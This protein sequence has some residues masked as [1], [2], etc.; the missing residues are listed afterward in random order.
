[1]TL[2]G[3][4]LIRGTPKIFRYLR[5]EKATRGNFNFKV[6][7]GRGGVK[8]LA[9]TMVIVNVVSKHVYIILI[10]KKV[11]INGYE[12]GLAA[13]N[14]GVP[15]GSVL[16]PLLFLLYTRDL[17]Q[18]IKLCKVHHFA[19]DTNLLCLSNPIKK[20]NKLVNGD[21]KH[22]A[23]WLNANKSSLSVKNL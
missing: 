22:L 21:L 4:V 19:G 2:R 13:L 9:E 5:G 16:G 18:A 8:T 17:N 1:M 12:S 20:L 3:D 23:N 7:G 14:C 6:R 10:E 11:Y 15:Q